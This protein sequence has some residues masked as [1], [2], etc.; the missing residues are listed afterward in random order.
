MRAIASLIA[1]V[2]LIGSAVTALADD[3][4][5]AGIHAWRNVGGKTCFVDHTHEG[6]GSGA[7]QPAAMN[8]AIKSWQSFTALEYGSDWASY[9]NSI[10]KSASCDKGTSTVNCSISSIPCKGGSMGR[11]RR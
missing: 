6:S 7:S 4:G 8:D 10:A 5:M 11:K 9:A 3:S 2:T 1:S